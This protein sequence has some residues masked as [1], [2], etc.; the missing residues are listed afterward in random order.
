ML[1]SFIQLLIKFRFVEDL[2]ATYSMAMGT[3]L[4]SQKSEEYRKLLYYRETAILAFCVLNFFFCLLATA[5]NLLVIHALWKA[6][7]IPANLKKLYLSLAISDLGVGL[8][9]QLMFGVIVSLMLAMAANGNYNFGFLCPTVL[10]VCYAAIYLLTCASFLT[11]TVIAVDRLLA[12]SLHLRYQE[13]VT[14]RRVSVA[15]ASLWFTSCVA[16][17]K[18]FL[19]PSRNSVLVAIVEIIGLFL[20]AVAYVRIYKTV[21]RHQKQIQSE[22]H[23]QNDQRKRAARDKK[24]TLSALTIYVVFL[25]CFLPNL[26]CIILLAGDSFRV[27]FLLANHISGC[28]VLVNSSLN[29]L[30]YCW[31]YREILATVKTAVKKLFVLKTLHE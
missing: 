1:L 22:V 3:H 7:S 28:L 4:C 5:G 8:F 23:L 13:I 11:I 9:A 15:L 6:S 17:L 24:S 30:V 10:I 21:R 18:F 20:T 29:P 26:C 19:L 12:I 16:A 2:K 31:R 27:S 25:A 14:P